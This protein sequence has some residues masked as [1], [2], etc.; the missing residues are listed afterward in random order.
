MKATFFGFISAIFHFFRLIYWY[1]YISLEILIRYFGIFNLYSNSNREV[2]KY[3]ENI[4][5][6]KLSGSFAS[7]V[8]LITA[9]NEGTGIGPTMDEMQSYLKGARYLVVDGNSYDDTAHVA[10]TLGAEV[11]FQKGKGDALRQGL[12]HISSDCEYV[13]LT[14]AD[15]T[16]PAEYVPEMIKIL[17]KDPTIGMV[18]GNRFNGHLV[19]GANA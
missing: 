7:T 1:G 14:D 6:E 8:V 17:D 13:V 11:I 2:T 18:C 5:L 4:V 16:Y 10:K 19:V 9:L 3:L 12:S 15:Y